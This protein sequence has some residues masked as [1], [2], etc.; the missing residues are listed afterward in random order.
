MYSIKILEKKDLSDYEFLADD[1]ILHELKKFDPE[2]NIAIGAR[3][4]DRVLGLAF[5]SVY[6]PEKGASISG[7][8]LLQVDLEYR[9]KGIGTALLR[10]MEKESRKRAC[11]KMTIGFKKVEQEFETAKRLL[12]KCGWEP[13]EI[14]GYSSWTT[15][16]RFFRDLEWVNQETELSCHDYIF[17]WTELT[18]EER[19]GLMEEEGPDSWKVE[20]TSPFFFEGKFEENTSLGLRVDGK[21]VGWLINHLIAPDTILYGSYFVRKKYRGFGNTIGLLLESVK[22]QREA[23]IPR[24]TWYVQA[25]DKEIKKLYQELVGPCITSEDECW[26]SSKVLTAQEDRHEV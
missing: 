8:S 26:Q 14:H 22:R 3:D 16:E 15:I 2:K 21:I 20:G 17:P 19:E 9:N 1:E 13:P 24:L 10:K 7:I 12:A 25:K 6:K 5:G 11:E 4:Q 18:E 23:E